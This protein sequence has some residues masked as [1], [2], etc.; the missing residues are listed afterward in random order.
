MRVD[1]ILAV[2]G[3]FLMACEDKQAHAEIA[4][5]K[6]QV[7][8]LEARNKRLIAHNS[9]LTA[10]EKD[11]EVTQK[12]VKFSFADSPWHFKLP[13]GAGAA[14]EANLLSNYDE[15]TRGLDCD[16][17][18]EMGVRKMLAGKWVILNPEKWSNDMSYKFNGSKELYTFDAQG[19]WLREVSREAYENPLH[20]GGYEKTQ[21]GSYI[22][23]R[24][25]FVD[26]G[27]TFWTLE[28]ETL[29]SVPLFGSE[30]KPSDGSKDPHYFLI[31]RHGI[32]P[33]KGTPS[34]VG[35]GIR[36]D[37]YRHRDHKKITLKKVE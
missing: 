17:L 7:E 8:V 30:M 27:S 5:L 6:E 29:E 3:T 10:K 25:A 22:V 12:P 37:A 19:G 35:F 36:M 21:A 14:S 31:A 4:R 32:Y 15:L 13:Q 24:H 23:R 26:S 1:C 34:E 11:S 16:S 9:T 28:L 2:S 18:T 33:D 20:A